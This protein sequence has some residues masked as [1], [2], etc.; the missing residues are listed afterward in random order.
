MANRAG[1]GDR[2]HAGAMAIA[3]ALTAAYWIDWF[4]KGR[5]QSAD[6]PEYVAFEESF[7]LADGYMAVL[8]VAA[9]RE[10]WKQRPAAVPLGIAAG[11]AN[12]FLAL[13]DL[14]FDLRRGNLRESTPEMQIEKAIIGASLVF[15]PLTAIRLWR[16]RSRLG[17]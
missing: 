17:A 7:P 3:A 2:I 9:A 1:L 5:V 15:G 8:Y 11:S 10:L 13:M 16:A 4:T 12:V 6:D 14:L